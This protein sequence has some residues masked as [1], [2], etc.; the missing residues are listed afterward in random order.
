VAPEAVAKLHEASRHRFQTGGV[1]FCFGAPDSKKP[2]SAWVWWIFVFFA[3]PAA[4]KHTRSAPKSAAH[5]KK[6]LH[7]VELETVK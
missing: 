1:I 6:N 4:G 5:R 3:L 7:K 2:D